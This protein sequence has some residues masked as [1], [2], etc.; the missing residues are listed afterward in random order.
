MTQLDIPKFEGDLARQFVPDGALRDIYVLATAGVEWCA[1]LT[2]LSDS[3][4]HYEVKGFAGEAVDLPKTYNDAIEE[5]EGRRYFLKIFVNGIQLNCHFFTDEEIELD[6][7][8]KEVATDDEFQKLFAFLV[9]LSK[10][11]RKEVILT[12]EN[13]QDAVI[14]RIPI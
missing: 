1:F 10:V 12:H 14:M 13:V 9:W 2:A 6:L 11:V 7:T 3:S 4:Y 5:K 8:S